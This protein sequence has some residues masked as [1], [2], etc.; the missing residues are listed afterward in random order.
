MTDSER[1]D[2]AIADLV[3]AAKSYRLSRA[4]D[5]DGLGGTLVPAG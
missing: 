4:V 1:C 5:D 2:K 3:S